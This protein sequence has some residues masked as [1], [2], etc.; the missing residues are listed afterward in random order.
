MLCPQAVPKDADGA[1]LSEPSYRYIGTNGPSSLIFMEVANSKLETDK[2]SDRWG[3]PVRAGATS[4]NRYLA[5]VN[6]DGKSFTALT[7]AQLNCCGGEFIQ[8]GGGFWPRP[9]WIPTTTAKSMTNDKVE[10]FYT[11]L[12]DRTGRDPY[13][14][15]LQPNA[16][17]GLHQT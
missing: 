1:E 15:A 3:K 11:N 9:W 5:V 12:K 2:S 16:Y 7:A 6:D 17:F 4:Y 13:S 14:A 10:L 8:N